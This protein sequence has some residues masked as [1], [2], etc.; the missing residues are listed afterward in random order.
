MPSK[1]YCA[2]HK[3]HYFQY[4]QQHKEELRL[5]IQQYYQTHKEEIK[6]RKKTSLFI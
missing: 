3:E 6:T 5:K 2:T 1:E 4:Y